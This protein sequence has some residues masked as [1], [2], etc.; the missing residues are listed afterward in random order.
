MTTKIDDRDNVPD[1]GRR[2]A[3]AGLRPTGWVLADNEG[4]SEMRRGIDNQEKVGRSHEPATD[5]TG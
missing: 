4:A 2:I 1:R 5:P 3:C